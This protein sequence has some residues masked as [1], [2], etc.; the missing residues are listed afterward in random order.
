MSKTDDCIFCKIINQE[1]PSYKIYED[2]NFYAFLDVF[3]MSLGHTLIIPK[4]HYQYVW[5]VEEIGTYFEVAKLIANNAQQVSGNKVVYSMIVGEAI[6]HAHIH[7]LP[8]EDNTF[9]NELL[10][11]FTNYKQKHQIEMLKPE[12]GKSM[13]QKYQIN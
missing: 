6:P 8:N 4:K 12:E 3:S 9:S 13:Q 2:E 1:I 11:F 10:E 5:D 7:I